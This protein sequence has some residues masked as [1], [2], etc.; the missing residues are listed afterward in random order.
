MSRPDG[1]DETGHCEFCKEGELTE[2]Q[3]HKERWICEDCWS[4]RCSKCGDGEC[5]V[6][7]R[8]DYI[9]TDCYSGEVDN[10]YESMRD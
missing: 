6:E 2:Y 10:A 3:T 7:F 1:K 4:N 5:E 8:D 9:C